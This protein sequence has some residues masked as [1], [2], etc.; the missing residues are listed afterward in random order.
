MSLK[1]SKWMIAHGGS[2]GKCSIKKTAKKE[3]TK[4][5]WE[6]GG[7]KRQWKHF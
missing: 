6:I 1:C 2:S 5:S 3:Q 4:Q 7:T